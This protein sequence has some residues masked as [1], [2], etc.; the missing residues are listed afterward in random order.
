MLQLPTLCAASHLTVPHQFN[1]CRLRGGPK[2]SRRITACR[3][4]S[5]DVSNARAEGVVRGVRNEEGTFAD[6]NAATESRDEEE[7]CA[8]RTSKTEVSIGMGL[9]RVGAGIGSGGGSIAAT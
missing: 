4:P 2:I 8:R 7:G 6:G 9:T 1:S 3:K 5:C